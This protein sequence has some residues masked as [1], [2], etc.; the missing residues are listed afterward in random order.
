MLHC[1]AY[2][3]L[4]AGNYEKLIKICP[5]YDIC[6]NHKCYVSPN[7]GHVPVLMLLTFGQM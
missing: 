4:H 6:P 2:L 5:Y 7:K 3:A 1:T